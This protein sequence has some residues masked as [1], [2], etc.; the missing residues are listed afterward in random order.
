M[1]LESLRIVIFKEHPVIDY[2]KTPPHPFEVYA[3]QE[4]MQPS[5]I[6]GG[7]F[8]LRQYCICLLVKLVEL[9]RSEI[10]AFI[11]FQCEEIKD[12]LPWL[13]KLEKLIVINEDIFTNQKDR[14][15]FEKVLGIIEI[16]R[17][18]FELNNSNQSVTKSFCF[19]ELKRKV[20]E[21]KCPKEKIS[22]L[23]EAK[24]DY[25]QNKPLLINPNEVSFDEK[26]ELEIDLINTQ[27]SLKQPNVS[28]IKKSSPLKGKING[29]LNQFVDVFYQLMF[30]IKV[31]DKPFLEADTNFVAELLSNYFIDKAGNSVSSE[32][33]KTILKPSRI[34]KR[35]KGNSRIDISN[36]N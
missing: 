27:L 15:Q 14:K 7:K 13:N 10:K 4:Q 8:N 30:E 29:N 1:Q 6:S 16:I 19:T 23:L 22:L 18:R 11:Q 31:D 26:V 33:V 9:N 34:E 24:T 28:E 5:F 21:Y 2:T 12:P 20:R 25:L 17:D 35:P 3:C 36:F 32:T